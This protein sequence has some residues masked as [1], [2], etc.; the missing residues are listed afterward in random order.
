MGDGIPSDNALS[1][2]VNMAK[3]KDSRVGMDKR[4]WMSAKFW[5]GNPN[6]MG[7]APC[8]MLDQLG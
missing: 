7:K 6:K 8:A 1:T 3:Y 5:H 4:P 2:C